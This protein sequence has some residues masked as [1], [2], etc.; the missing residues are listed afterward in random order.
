M[1][2]GTNFGH[3]VIQEDPFYFFNNLQTLQYDFGRFW[4]EIR[5]RVRQGNTEKLPIVIKQAARVIRKLI[6]Y[7]NTLALFD[8]QLWRQLLA[9]LAPDAFQLFMET[10]HEN[11]VIA[12]LTISEEVASVVRHA[13]PQPQYDT[14]ELRP[15]KPLTLRVL[16]PPGTPWQEKTDQALLKLIDQQ[17][18][19]TDQYL[20]QRGPIWEQTDRVVDG[21][22][23]VVKDPTSR[24]DTILSLLRE[25]GPYHHLLALIAEEFKMHAPTRPAPAAGQGAVLP[26]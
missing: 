5:R 8:V 22:R 25:G 13:L 20:H 15:G 17:L 16:L 24:P 18:A 10:N 3:L 7:A 6:V 9:V 4:R 2:V 12:E 11:F 1:V 23:N 26:P 19:I 14:I 21:L